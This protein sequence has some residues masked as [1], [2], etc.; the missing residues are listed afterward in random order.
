MTEKDNESS[1]PSHPV[2][3]EAFVSTNLSNV[4]GTV[5]PQTYALWT[6]G[7]TASVTMAGVRLSDDQGNALKI[8]TGDF[9]SWGKNEL[10]QHVAHHYSYTTLLGNYT[11]ALKD[12][13]A[14]EIKGQG[15]YFTRDK[16]IP[17]DSYM[18]GEAKLKHADWSGGVAVVA[19]EHLARNQAYA[20]F[21]Y[22]QTQ[23]QVG[24]YIQAP[25]D[26]PDISELHA[27]PGSTLNF[28]A[29]ATQDL[30]LD[31]V[32][33]LKLFGSYEAGSLGQTRVGAA[34]EASLPHGV[35][36][37]F[38]GSYNSKA[39]HQI[40]NVSAGAELPFVLNKHDEHTVRGIVITSMGWVSQYNADPHLNPVG[41]V[42]LVL[43]RDVGHGRVP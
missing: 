33:S 25:K 29:T 7:S 18:N 3:T 6:F 2:Q 19:G 32:Q 13:N 39:V 22:K 27:I 38:D 24:A 36:I 30:H 43:K 31:K 21:G 5:Y 42:S 17:P 1:S 26:W 28:R 4:N 8:R 12:G 40:G 20:T 9:A 35:K 11:F 37:Q 34:Y 23:V 14:L 15:A 41:S 10:F 16:A